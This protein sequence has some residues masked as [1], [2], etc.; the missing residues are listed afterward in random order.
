MCALL[1]CV[2]GSLVICNPA[3]SD[4]HNSTKKCVAL[5][6]NIG[7]RLKDNIILFLVMHFVHNIF[8]APHFCPT[9][10]ETY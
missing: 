9:R 8:Y 4:T 10:N 5:L 6:R 3:R 1:G 2:T 7:L